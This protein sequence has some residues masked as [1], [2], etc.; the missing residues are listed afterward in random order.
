M[1][2]TCNVLRGDENLQVMALELELPEVTFESDCKVLINCLYD[3]RAQCPWEVSVVEGI[4][5]WASFRNCSF[6]WGS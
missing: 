3:A 5:F 6:S 1:M 4:K 2:I